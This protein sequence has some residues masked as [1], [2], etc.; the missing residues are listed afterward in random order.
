MFPREGSPG[1]LPELDNPL[2]GGYMRPQKVMVFRPFSSFG[3]LILAISVDNK[4]CFFLWS[5]YAFFL[6]E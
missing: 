4:T 6:E 2:Y 1:I 3:V 5:R